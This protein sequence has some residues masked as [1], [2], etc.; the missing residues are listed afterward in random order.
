MFQNALGLYTRLRINFIR[1]YMP[2]F[3]SEIY[4]Q[5]KIERFCMCGVEYAN[6]KG[7]LGNVEC[8][9]VLWR[10]RQGNWTSRSAFCQGA[11]MSYSSMITF[12]PQKLTP[13]PLADSTSPFSTSLAQLCDFLNR[14]NRKY[15]FNRFFPNHLLQTV[16]SV[17]FN[18]RVLTEFN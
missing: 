9:A 18:W 6:T 7:K 14:L 17:L 12:K 5:M 13:S 1:V 4:I 2:K 8:T 3:Y 15:F 11:V 10:H 16:I